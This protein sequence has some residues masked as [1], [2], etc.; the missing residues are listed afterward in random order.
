MKMELRKATHK[1]LMKVVRA[2][3]YKDLPYI[4]KSQENLDYNKKQLYV[5]ANGEKVLA[6]ASLVWESQY[7]YFAVKRLCILNKHNCG[8]GIARFALHE[9]QK[10]VKGRI[11]GTPW[12]D[13]A[14]VRHIFE[15]EGFHLEYIFS[16]KWCFYVKE[17]EE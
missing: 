3:G 17:I 13:N 11:G 9:I 1:D 14:P 12:I 10:E 15:S 4:T 6:C 7:E 16:E 5:V 8:K 2:I